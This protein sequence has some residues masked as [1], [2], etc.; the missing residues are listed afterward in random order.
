MMHVFEHIIYVRHE[1][2]LSLLCYALTPCHHSWLYCAR[3]IV[4]SLGTVLNGEADN[5]E[6]HPVVYEPLTDYIEEW[7]YMYSYRYS[8]GGAISCRKSGVRLIVYLVVR[9]SPM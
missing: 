7:Y 5:D 6:V 9:R 1:R 8:H 3:N 2:L 4:D